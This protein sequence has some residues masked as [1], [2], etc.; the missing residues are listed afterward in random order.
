MSALRTYSVKEMKVLVTSVKNN[1]NFEWKIDKIKSGPGVV[2]YLIGIP[3][4]I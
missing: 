4:S 1:V 2:L 3:K